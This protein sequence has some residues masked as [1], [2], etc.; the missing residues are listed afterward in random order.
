LI[1]YVALALTAKKKSLPT[2]PL[3]LCAFLLVWERGA[4]RIERIESRVLTVLVP[5]SGRFFW[6][7]NWILKGDI[8]SGWDL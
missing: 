2:V 1:L 8:S 3:L 5:S 6:L 7:H 4:D